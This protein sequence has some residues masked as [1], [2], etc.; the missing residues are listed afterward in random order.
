MKKN[1]N[2][3]KKYGKEIEMVTS[4][5]LNC[6]DANVALYRKKFIRIPTLEINPHA[7][8]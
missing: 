2:V 6:E 1:T 8:L 3:C 5:C 7:H 4:S